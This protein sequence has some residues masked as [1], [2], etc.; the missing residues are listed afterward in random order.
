MQVTG[1]KALAFFTARAAEPLP[2]S[3]QSFSVSYFLMWTKGT[4]KTPVTWEI[5]LQHEQEQHTFQPYGDFCWLCNSSLT[6][7]VWLYW[8]SGCMPCCKPV[9]PSA[10]SSLW[11]LAASVLGY[12]RDALSF[13]CDSN[14]GKQ[15]TRWYWFPCKLFSFFLKYRGCRFVSTEYPSKQTSFLEAPRTE[16]KYSFHSKSSV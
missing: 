9:S 12:I 13:E 4:G 1:N 5:Q 10:A 15:Q 7:M 2:V 3:V 11:M 14:A 16:E 8:M 6:S